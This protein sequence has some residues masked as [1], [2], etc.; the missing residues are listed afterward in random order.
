MCAM[1][2]VRPEFLPNFLHRLFFDDFFLD[3]KL[4]TN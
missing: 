1:F 3:S 2:K 4:E